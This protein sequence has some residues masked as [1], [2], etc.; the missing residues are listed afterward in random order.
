[1]A[2]T[3]EKLKTKLEENNFQSSFDFESYEISPEDKKFILEKEKRLFLNFKKNN[4]ILFE[5]CKD[6]YEVSQKLKENNTFMAWY[7]ACGLSKDT[8]SCMLK[9]YSVFLEFPD[10]KAYIS[11]LSDLAIKY[12]T[13]KDITLDERILIVDK[14]IKNA[15]EIKEILEPYKEKIHL[16]F[17]PV[18]KRYF[19]FKKINKIKKQIPEVT[20]KEFNDIKESLRLYK[21]QIKEIE[22]LLEE[23]E[24]S[25]ENKN[26]KQLF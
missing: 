12:L 16:E 1:M 17:T 25:F 3:L 8:V 15:E 10:K 24:K 7:T 9:R 26:N 18:T 20:D 6:L 21:Q 13:H 5:L 2:N 23:K 4:E 11:S 14:S 19:D 22:L